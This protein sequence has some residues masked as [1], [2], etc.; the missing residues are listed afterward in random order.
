M[1]WFK[2]AVGT[3]CLLG[4]TFAACGDA[5]VAAFGQSV[6]PTLLMD[7]EKLAQ[8]KMRIEK[9]DPKLKP[10]MDVLIAKADEALNDGPYS[11]TDKKKVA[12]SGDR[13]DYAS[14]S[15]YWWPDPAKADGLPY[16]R[17]DGETN[18]DSQSLAGSDRQRIEKVGT[19][20]EA[21]GLAYYLTG[22]EKYAQKAAEI[23]RVWFLDPATRM[24]PNLN[25]AQCRLGHN[26]GT[27]SGVL[28][29]RMMTRGLEGS[30]LIAGSSALSDTEREGLRAW[31]GE[32]LQWLKT[33]KLPLEEA[34]ATN[35]HG[36]FFDAQTMYFALY[37]GNKQEAVKLANNAIQKRILSQIRPDGSMPEELARTRPNFYS[38]YNLHA[39]FVIANL[40]EK[41]GVDIWN[42]G[43]A[44]L[45]AGLDYLAPYA[46]PSKPWPHESIKEN[47]RMN[48]FP[49]LMMAESAYPDGNY[50]EMLEKLPLT[51]RETR[52][53]NLAFPLMR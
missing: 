51:D 14:Y 21:L 25:H 39:M 23:L 35:N 47:D 19:H 48:M 6:P 41:V 33:G 45:R 32:Y 49:I 29:G 15:R 30:L 52:I 9:G 42:A 31:V 24:N 22:E 8:T 7:G 26:T 44:R 10:A 34:A 16:I 36:C 12:P 37:S 50:L 20:T 13:H 4:F 38:N 53:E 1:N 18:P 5:G 11:V 46:D 40:A 28:D 3:V 27:K 2:T 43:D 17:R